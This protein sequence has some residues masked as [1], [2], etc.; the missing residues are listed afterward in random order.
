MGV[1]NRR[2]REE[3]PGKRGFGVVLE[4]T[5]ESHEVEGHFRRGK[6][7]S[8]GRLLRGPKEGGRIIKE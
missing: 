8:A 4:K 1:V 2:E 7:R 5:N 3:K 6:N